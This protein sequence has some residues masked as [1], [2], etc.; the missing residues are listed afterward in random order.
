MDIEDEEIQEFMND[1]CDFWDDENW[2]YR[3]RLDPLPDPIEQEQSAR[4]DEMA[5][6]LNLLNEW[7]PK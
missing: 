6:V 2:K 1:A 3:E 5:R 4:E 7:L